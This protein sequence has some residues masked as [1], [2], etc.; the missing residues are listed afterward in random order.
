MNKNINIIA[1]TIIANI[2]AANIIIANI[3]ILKLGTITISVTSTA[4]F[5]K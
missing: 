5:I 1:D 3:I 4:R 2:T